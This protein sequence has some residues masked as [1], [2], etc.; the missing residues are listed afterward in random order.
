MSSLAEAQ[1]IYN[2]NLV[3]ERVA[4]VRAK[5]NETRRKM[6]K[7]IFE[8]KAQQEAYYTMQS[9]FNDTVAQ[10]HQDAVGNYVGEHIKAYMEAHYL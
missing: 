9:E 1:V 7:T 8:M 3:A 4:K 6:S 10:L 2:A 5:T